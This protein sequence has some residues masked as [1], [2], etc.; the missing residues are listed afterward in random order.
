MDHLEKVQGVGAVA[1]KERSMLKT[2][3]KMEHEWEGLD[4]RVMAYKDTGVCAHVHDCTCVTT[5]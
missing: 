1:T 5:A 2:M 4:F 3:E